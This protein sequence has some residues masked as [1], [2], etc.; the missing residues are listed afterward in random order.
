MSMSM[1]MGLGSSSADTP[2]PRQDSATCAAWFLYLVAE[3][4]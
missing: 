2:Q 3:K 1:G 4:K